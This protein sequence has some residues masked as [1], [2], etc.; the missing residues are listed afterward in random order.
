MRGGDACDEL[1]RGDVG[2]V[3]AQ[4]D[5]VAVAVCDDSTGV[6]HLSVF[7]YEVHDKSAFRGDA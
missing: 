2:G 6:G 4:M 3:E 7:I 1:G 5:A